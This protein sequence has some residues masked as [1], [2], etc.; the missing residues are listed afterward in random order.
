[1]LHSRL[2]RALFLGCSVFLLPA[3]NQ[4]QTFPFNSGPIPPCDTS[5]FTANVSGIGW[6]GSS[7]NPWSYFLSELTINVTSDHPQTLSIALTS[8]SGTTLL[9]SA[10]NGAGGQNYTNTVFSNSA[11]QNITAGTAP[12]TGN[13]V[14]QG[15]GFNAFDGEYADGTWTISIADT[16]CAN[17]G[18]GPGGTWTPGW[19]DGSGNGGFAFGFVGPPPCMGGIPGGLEYICP[20]ETVDILG[21]YTTQ[22]P[23]YSYTISLNGVPV[24][25]PAA[26]SS[27]GSYTIDAVDPFDGCW[28]WA[29]FDVY[30]DVQIDLGADLTVNYCNG[31]PPV[32]LTALFNVGSAWP[33]WSLNGAAISGVEAASTSTPGVYQLIAANNAGC[34]DTALVVM[35]ASASML[36]GPDQALSSCDGA[37]VDLTLLYDLTGASGSWSFGG[38]PVPDPTAVGQAGSYTLTA[39]TPGGCTDDA[40]VTLSVQPQPSLGADQSVSFCS[41]TTLD[42]TPLFNTAGLATQW[43]FLGIPVTQPASVV[44]GG[45]YQLIASVG[46]CSDTALVD[47]TAHP[48]PNL[49]ANIL[50]TVCDG[51]TEDI[52][53]LYNTLG[54]STIWSYGGMSIA[55]PEAISEAGTYLLVGINTNGCSDS[56]QVELEVTTPPTLG[57][58]QTVIIC[59]GSSLNLATLFNTAGNTVSWTL[60]GGTVAEPGAVS[61][62]GTY[63]LIATDANGCTSTAT[64]TMETQP[65]P[66]LDD[67]QQLLVCEGASVDLTSLYATNGLSA[68]W[69]LNGLALADPTS[70]ELEETYRLVAMDI[71]GCTDTAWVDVQLSALPDLGSDQDFSICPWQSVDLTAA[72]PIGDLN[73][74]YSLNGE[75]VVA[76][77]EVDSAGSYMIIVANDAG[78]MD[79]ATATIAVLECMCEADFTENARCSQD[80]VQ[81]TLLDDSAVQS[82]RWEFGGAA[83]AS[84]QLAPLVA[85]AAA[86]D[87]QVTLEATLTCGVVRVVRSIALADCSDSCTVWIPNSFT[88]DG[89]AMN[90]A[91][92]WNGD[93]APEDYRLSVF[94]RFGEEVFASSDP[95]LSWDGTCAGKPAPSGVYAYRVGYRLPYQETKQVVG[96]VTLVR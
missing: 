9:L 67:D 87:I 73:A 11:W 48:F 69:S 50:T 80:P 81:F 68:V 89:D 4:A 5:T 61:V 20:G 36:L 18:S 24:P 88:P 43:S 49:G 63:Q 83:N 16:A 26:V 28:Y 64:A 51:Q 56:A 39:S 25:D 2:L 37:E 94:D 78:C 46:G 75:P 65:A 27:P 92:R 44:A 70:V 59:D 35:D 7:W 57:P 6:L 31:A 21:Y 30:A 91:W 38:M 13:W 90:D 79:Q 86:N 12:F 40:D 10:F 84:S 96:S 76:P 62:P 60:N 34:N 54:L 15:G 93:C 41:N 42:L 3:S 52:T 82:V 66:A 19:F 23:W 71:N 85:F 74:T 58:D 8:P 32:D 1:M 14:P 55:D 45:P 77:N 22:A 53:G 47:V 17:G 29:P 33:A 72:F 95:Y